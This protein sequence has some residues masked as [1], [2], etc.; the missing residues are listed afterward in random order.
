[1]LRSRLWIRLALILVV[2]GAIAI[3]AGEQPWG[4]A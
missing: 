3:I 2:L 1:M 4:P